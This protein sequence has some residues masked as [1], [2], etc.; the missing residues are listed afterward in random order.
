MDNLT[1]KHNNENNTEKIRL[2]VYLARSGIGSRR[3]CE[4]YICEGRVSVNGQIVT[5]QGIKVSNNDSVKF[6]GKICT[7]VRSNVYLA[8]NKPVKYLCT[9]SDPEG[10]PLA[11]ELL[12]GINVRVFHVGRLDFLSSGLILYTNDGEFAKIASHPSSGI[13]KEYEVQGTLPIT[14]AMLQD[15]KSGIIENG[16]KLRIK[17]YYRHSAH[18]VRLVLV[19]GKNREIRR[20]FKLYN[21]PL[22]YIQRTRIGSIELGKLPKGHYRHLSEREIYSIY[23]RKRK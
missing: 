6:D 21:I 14:D 18:R 22:K 10:R 7:P 20:V 1:P 9:N 12:T 4:Q 8:L 16:E 15:F 5:E 17:K 13:E 3:T 19:E 23:K 11:K 2:Q